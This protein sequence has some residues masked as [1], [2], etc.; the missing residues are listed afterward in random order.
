MKK[1]LTLAPGAVIEP[2]GNDV[3]VMIPGNTDILR[4]SGPAADTLRTIVAGQ[5]IDP[6]T[7]TVLEL[8]NQGIISPSGMSRRGLIRAGAIGTGAGIAALTMPSV[9]AAA[10][11][12]NTVL[13]RWTTTLSGSEYT[14]R[15]IVRFTAFGFDFPNDLGDGFFAT[16]SPSGGATPPGPLVGLPTGFSPAATIGTDIFTNQDGVRGYQ[17]SLIAGSGGPG[18]DFVQWEYSYTVT[19][20]GDISASFVWDDV[21]YQVIFKPQ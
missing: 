13:G 4:I 14:G 17:A 2:V 8:A 20:S 10:S 19:P 7:P 9:A 1:T 21:T 12:E 16:A 18:T 6:T 3:M 15:Q 11:G 5:P